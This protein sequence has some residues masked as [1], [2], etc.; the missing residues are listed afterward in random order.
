M[1][2]AKRNVQRV[3]FLSSWF[4]N[5]I[6][7]LNGDFVERHA[8][9]VS[10][11]CKTAV[12]HVCP[13]PALHGRIMEILEVQKNDL[14]EVIIYIRRINSRFKS[15]E[16][17]FNNWLYGI[18]YLTGYFIVKREIGRPDVIHA[19]VIIPVSRI[20]FLLHRLTG[21]PYII[22]EH[23][24]GF[25]AE[26]IRIDD[27]YKR[28]VSESHALVPVTLN[29]RDAM[30]ASGFNNRYFVVPNVVNTSIFK[31]GEST[32]HSK[33]LLHVSSMKEEH[34]NISGII[35]SIRTLKNIRNDFVFTF[36]GDASDE[37]KTM[38]S[39]LQLSD[40]IEFTGEVAHLKVA[41]LMQNSDALVMFSNIEN[42][43][44]VIIEALSSGIP[45]IST[46]AGGI[47]E[48]LDNRFGMLVERG[49]EKALTAAMEYLLDHLHEYDKKQLHDYAVKNFSMGVIASKFLDIY[50]QAV[51]HTKK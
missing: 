16:R 11:L 20:A 33:R 41:S 26:D 3:L 25:L 1:V 22:S 12:L 31:P 19:N 7:P 51:N 35:R 42:L 34:K 13:D 8:I 50:N 39:E 27:I 36:A 43:P 38:V 9:A 49:D 48:V 2:T 24:T 23:W 15:F 45:V 6:T 17:L 44:C 21:I 5:R 14:F 47:A 4:P 40:C 10:E 37:Q 29:L 18:A 30:V 28:P 46:R 32:R